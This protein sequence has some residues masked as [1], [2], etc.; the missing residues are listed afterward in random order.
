MKCNLTLCRRE[1]YLMLFS[2]WEEYRVKGKTVY[3]FCV[4]DKVP[5][6]LLIW[7][8]RKNRTPEG[9]VRSMTSLYEGTKTRVRVNCELSEEL[10]VKVGMHQEPVMSSLCF[11]VAVDVVTE[12]AREGVLSELLY[13][14]DLVMMSKTIEILVNTF[15]KWKE[16]SIS[17][18]FKVNHEIIKWWSAVAPQR[19]TCLTVRW[20]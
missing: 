15:I 11:L 9:L 20:V 1:E 19:M 7:A 3:V 10:E 6:K 16:A 13:A 17:K 12:L 8:M 14:D 4:F 2:S 5:R 18:G